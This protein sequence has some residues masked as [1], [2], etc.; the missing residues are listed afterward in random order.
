MGVTKN[1][2]DW[3]VTGSSV[4]IENATGAT[5]VDDALVQ[6]RLSAW[7]WTALRLYGIIAVATLSEQSKHTCRGIERDPLLTIRDCTMN[8]FDGTLMSSLN[9]MEPFHEHFGTRMDG[10]GTGILF[11]IYA[12]GNLAGALTAAPASDILGRRFGMCVGSLFIIL[13]AAL[14]ASARNVSQFMGGRF[15]IGFGVSVS[16]TAGPTYLVEVALPQWR[17]VLGGLYNVVGYYSGALG[18]CQ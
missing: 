6:D 12:V 14:E 9:A 5:S 10:A 3:P 4:N 1:E 16:N 15:L 8:G 13:G 2:K 17:G 7:S 18:E 11:A